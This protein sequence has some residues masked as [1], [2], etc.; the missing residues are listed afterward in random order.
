M[1]EIVGVIEI[2]ELEIGWIVEMIGIENG[3]V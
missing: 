2:V 3:I 1:A